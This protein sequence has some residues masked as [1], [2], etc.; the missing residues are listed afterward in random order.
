MSILSGIKNFIY[1]TIGVDDT[2][3]AKTKSVKSTKSA[4]TKSVKSDP[5]KTSEP[6][7]QQNPSP[8]GD[9]VTMKN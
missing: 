5:A 1:Q 6:V 8:V 7:F 4:S 3:S 9:V 2:K